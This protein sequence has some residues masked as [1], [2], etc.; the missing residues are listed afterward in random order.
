MWRIWRKTVTSG[1]VA[2]AAIFVGGMADAADLVTKAPPAPTANCPPPGEWL[3][4]DWGG[5]RTSLLCQGIAFEFGYVGELAYNATGG[6]RHMADYSDQYDAGVTLDT[7]RLFGWHGG[8][9]QATFTER[10]G[11]NE[12]EDA[13]LNTLM[14]VNEV[15]GRGQTVRL[16]QFWYD[17]KFFNDLVSWKIGRMGVGEDFATFSCN[18]QNLTFCGS[19]PGNIAGNYIFNWPISE[20]G[21]RVKFTLPSFGYFEIGV[22]DQNPAYLGVN[23]QIAP[24]WFSGSTG[25]LIPAELAWL[26]T[27]GDGTLPGSYKF[28]AW[29]D[30]STASDVVLDINGNPIAVTG[31]PAAQLQGQRYGAYVNFQQQLTR[32]SSANP[33]GGLNAFL[34]AA[35]TNDKTATTDWQV[36]GGLVYTGP[37]SWR[38]NDDVAFAVGTTHVGDHTANAE[39]LQNALL[40]FGAVAVQHSEV[41]MELYYTIRP[42]PGLLFRPNLQ[43]IITPGGTSQNGNAFVL[44]LK[45]IA[46][47]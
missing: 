17:Q 1:I 4:G 37:L 43:Y 38:P 26:P 5:L 46:N 44:G 3:F 13:G 41:A 45:T 6:T 42:V 30:T 40:G 33:K 18:F 23:N 32:T 36:A 2:L 19:D 47:F 10:T 12:S 34:N 20:W 16:T 24:V 11:R 7:Q 28:G 22:Y 25:V 21:T 39:A 14:L 35:W 15:F 31:L 9:F 8:T 27:F 29:Y